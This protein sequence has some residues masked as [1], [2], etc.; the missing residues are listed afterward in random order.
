MLT[1]IIIP[2]GC[3]MSLGTYCFGDCTRLTTI[4][5]PNTIPNGGDESFYNDR[6]LE[7]VTLQNGWNASRINLS[8]SIKY[9]HDTILSWFNALADRTGDTAYTLTIGATNIAKMTA[10]EIAIATNK[11]WNIA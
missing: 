7:F 6:N 9:S 5:L 3:T 11:N 1:E 8:Y 2:D 10:E 4:Y